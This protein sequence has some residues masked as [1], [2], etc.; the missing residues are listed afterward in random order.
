MNVLVTGGA[1]YIGS[2]AVHELI[3]SGHSVTIFDDLS[4]GHAAAVPAQAAFVRGTIHDAALLINTI[5][6][7]AIDAVVHFAAASLVGESMQH[8]ALYYQNNVAGTLSLLT[9][10]HDTAVSKIVFSSTAA[11]YGEPDVWPITEDMPT[12]PTNVYGRTKLVIEGMLADFARAY[13]LQYVSLRYF[14]AAGA[15]A[16]GGIGEDHSPETH[17]IPLLLQT[18]LGQRAAIDVYGVDYPTPDGTCIRDYIHVTDLA[19][20]HVLALEHLAQG[21]ASR[22]YNL[23]S[24]AGF[25]VREV[26]ARAKAIT[27]IDF[28]V[29][30]AA[31]RPGDPAV[32]V[33]SSARICQELGWQPR[34]SDLDTIIRS[35]WDWHKNKPQ[36]FRTR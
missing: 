12:Q 18:A 1:G 34:F 24:Q 23:G 36:G 21:G 2:H 14:N 35:A 10:M 9:A 31:R 5:Q 8:P 7:H 32:L 16:G 4:T 19:N 17:L 30:E 25:S 22:V 13:G 3:A 33:A 15:L 11:V 20:A 26:I 29:R 28:T 6:E 27:G